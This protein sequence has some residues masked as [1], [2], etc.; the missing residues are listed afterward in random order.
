MNAADVLEAMSESLLGIGPVPDQARNVL[1]EILDWANRIDNHGI[2]EID[3]DTV[4]TRTADVQ[5]R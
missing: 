1:Q 4:V 5:V 2:D 3:D